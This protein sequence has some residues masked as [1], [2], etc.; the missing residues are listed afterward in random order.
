MVLT[1]LGQAQ[2]MAVRTDFLGSVEPAY[3]KVGKKMEYN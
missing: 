2:D 1:A 3:L